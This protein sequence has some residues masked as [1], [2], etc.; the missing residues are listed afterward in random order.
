MFPFSS[1]IFLRPIKRLLIVLFAL[2]IWN[3]S[4]AQQELFNAFDLIKVKHDG[5]EFTAEQYLSERNQLALTYKGIHEDTL[6]RYHTVTLGLCEKSKFVKEEIEALRI[7]GLIYDSRREYEIAD[8]Y[9]QK[10]LHLAKKNESDKQVARILN[11]LGGLDLN[12]GNYAEALQYYYD[13]LA[14]SELLKDKPMMSMVYNNLANVFYFRK[15]LDNAVVFY[16]KAMAIDQEL[17]DSLGILIGFNNLGELY[18]SMGNYPL[19]LEN[20]TMAN[21][22]S[23]RLQNKEVGLASLVSLGQLFFEQKDYVKAD[24]IFR[25]AIGDSKEQSDPLYQAKAKLGLANLKKEQ[26]LF[27]EAKEMVEK[28]IELAIQIGHKDLISKGYALLAEVYSLQD[29]GQLAYES[30]KQHK[31]YADS[32]LNLESERAASALRVNYEKAQ[33]ELN[34]Q[35]KTLQQRWLIF[36]GFA[37]FLTAVIIA[38]M[39]NRNR[40][41][42]N[43]ANEVLNQK[44]LKIEKQRASLEKALTHL[45]AT[46]NQ[47]IQSEKMASLGEMTSGIAHEIQNP[48]NFVNNLSDIN[49]ELLEELEI[50]LA[51]PAIEQDKAIIQDCIENLEKNMQIILTHG[52]RADGI[53]KSMLYHSRNAGT[54]KE[55]VDINELCKDYIKLSFQSMRAKEKSFDV[56]I[57]TQ[58]AADAGKVSVIPQELGRVLLNLC[59]NA[60]Q[61]M[62]SRVTNNEPGYKPTLKMSTKKGDNTVIIEVE[63]N[64]P[65]IPEEHLSKIFLPFFTTK[66]TGEGTG[67]GLSISYD[68]ITKGHG[69]QFLV[70]S[71]K[72]SF[73]RFTIVLPV[74]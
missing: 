74:E 36:S 51:K 39:V 68:I 19:A 45:K 71:E 28:G 42:A 73:T 34:F 10:A 46:Q 38:L 1:Q 21:L 9:I 18:L 15:D 24:S 48:L 44:N 12:R 56:D 33:A 4:L 30:Y 67:L 60:F 22:L 27:S 17:N 37:A 70:N 13:A 54:I 53:V 35:R 49:T 69:G 7:M 59:N 3:F 66:P 57:E 43:K 23:K 65:G 63:D 25:L 26:G 2:F 55:L 31:L 20:L 61:A 16:R 72:D 40:A 47:L 64:G 5:G 41:R 62:A 14:L 58:W 6:I 8:T 50:E 52:R 11:N 29:K 32:L